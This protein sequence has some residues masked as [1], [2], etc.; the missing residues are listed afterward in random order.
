ML[1]SAASRRIGFEGRCT[2]E[3]TPSD[4]IVRDMNARRVERWPLHLIRK[5]GNSSDRFS[6]EAGR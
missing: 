5:Y 2:L 1:P 3:V 6:F 4:I